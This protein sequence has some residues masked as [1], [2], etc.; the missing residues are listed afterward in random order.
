MAEALTTTE[1]QQLDKIQTR[2]QKPVVDTSFSEAAGRM[3]D[4][5]VETDWSVSGYISNEAVRNRNERIDEMFKTGE[6]DP[7]LKARFRSNGMFSSG[8]D[9]D[10]VAHE[11]NVLNGKGSMLEQAD[12]DAFREN[13]MQLRQGEFARD[14]SGGDGYTTAG[15]IAGGALAGAADPGMLAASVVTLG[16]VGAYSAAVGGVRSVRTGLNVAKQLG[17]LV[18]TA[19]TVRSVTRWQRA[20]QLGR[21]AAIEGALTEAG[22][23]MVNAENRERIGMDYTP[24]EVLA[25]L[26]F[27]AA[28]GAVM[29]GVPGAAGAGSVN[30]NLAATQADAVKVLDTLI[31]DG[32]RTA[33]IVREM[34]A[35]VRDY[36]GRLVQQ[37]LPTKALEPRTELSTPAFVGEPRWIVGAD[38]EETFLRLVRERLPEP[39]SVGLRQQKAP[40]RKDAKIAMP[41]GAYADGAYRG[42]SGRGFMRLINGEAGWDGSAAVTPDPLRFSLFTSADRAAAKDLGAFVVRFNPDAV[43]GRINFRAKDIGKQW[44]RGDVTFHV[45]RDSKFQPEGRGDNFLADAIDDVTVPKEVID[46]PGSAPMKKMRKQL[47]QAGFNR[48]D[49]TDG[50][51]TFKRKSARQAPQP[52][53]TD[54]LRAASRT[55]EANVKA[56]MQSKELIKIAPP[57][58]THLPVEYVVSRLQGA[59]R[60]LK[61]QDLAPPQGRGVPEFESTTGVKLFTDNTT[62]EGLVSEAQRARI[63]DDFDR[64]MADNPDAIAVRLE[65]DTDVNATPSLVKASEVID[66]QMAELDTLRNAMTTCTTGGA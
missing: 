1:L 20:L 17:D 48:V 39:T 25:T 59:S 40:T 42:L 9:Y 7:E 32:G 27:G 66:K 11:Y 45:K 41:M 15:V 38:A 10:R 13:D 46:K 49:N 16:A 37:D 18:E 19:D 47:R 56:L 4:L 34:R 60:R 29:G 2:K 30:K 21:P 6:L 65:D 58:A 36:Q 33:E 31:A 35:G 63:A 23:M 61:G 44:E 3:L 53:K 43:V 54:D 24:D 12:L 14:M 5:T 52:Q 55:L 51:V 8:V 22:L 57:G 62:P 26:G 50:S 28:F 64:M